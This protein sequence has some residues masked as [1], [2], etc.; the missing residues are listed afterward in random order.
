MY[1]FCQANCVN[2]ETDCVK[3]KHLV[4]IRNRE[5]KFRHKFGGLPQRN[6]PNQIGDCFYELSSSIGFDGNEQKP[7][8]PHLPFGSMFGTY[9]FSSPVPKK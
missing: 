7:M 3:V 2:F 1:G 8:A 6:R 4:H 5:T 9:Q